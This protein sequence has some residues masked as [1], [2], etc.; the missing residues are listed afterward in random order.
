M[1]SASVPPEVKKIS[2]GSAPMDCA[3]RLRTTSTSTFA[4]RPLRCVLDG[5]P[6]LSIIRIISSLTRGSKG[7][8]AALSKKITPIS[9][10]LGLLKD[11]S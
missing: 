11:R 1:L 6:K 8:V 7:V 9:V 4:P 2:P 5:L 10:Q 3:I